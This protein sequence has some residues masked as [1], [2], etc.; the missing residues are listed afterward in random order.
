MSDVLGAVLAVVLFPVVFIGFWMA[1]CWLLAQVS[2]WAGLA[3]R[4]ETDRPQG[5]SAESVSGRLGLT[6][7]NGVLHVDGAD[8][9]L[10]LAVSSL[11]RAGHPPLHIPWTELEELGASFH[12]F[13]AMVRVRLG[14]DGPVL[15]LP[16]D[17]WERA[18]A[19]RYG[20]SPTG[21]EGALPGAS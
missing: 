21:Q 9:G 15:V 2:G 14:A 10:L 3:R 1:V 16:R 20:R 19:G 5:A 18:G 8:D 7:Y 11:F 4:Y 17:T 13:Y 6:S 12:L